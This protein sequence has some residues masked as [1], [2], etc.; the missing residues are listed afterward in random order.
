MN[1]K[2]LDHNFATD[3]VTFPLNDEQDSVEGEIYVSIN[4]TKRNSKDFK[5]S[6]QNE[7][8]R[9]TIHGALHL[10]GYDDSTS[11]LKSK[12]K[13]KEDYY[14]NL[15]GESEIVENNWEVS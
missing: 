3:V 6:H 10:A 11:K 1:K 4:T 5:V 2:Y 12:M 14:L 8:L 9:V 13:D 15:V 7:L